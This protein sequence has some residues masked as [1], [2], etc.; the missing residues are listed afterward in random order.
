MSFLKKLKKE[1][2]QEDLKTPSSVEKKKKTHKVSLS[3]KAKPKTKTKAK[4]PQETR[5]KKRQ[6]PAKEGLLCVDVFY[7]NGKFI[8]QAPIAGTEPEEIDISIDNGMLSIKGSRRNPSGSE[9]KDY[10]H[11]ECWWG[12]FSRQIILPDDIDI[13]RIKASWQKNVLIITAPR[14]VKIKKK[15]VN[16]NLKE[17]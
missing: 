9:E 10:F 7:S 1:L 17:E 15:K 5:P 3:V 12:P 8:I 6:W 16:I 14:V 11:Q 4:A 2:A 13:Q